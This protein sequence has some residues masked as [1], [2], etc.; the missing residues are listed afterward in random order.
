[1]SGGI[2]QYPEADVTF[3]HVFKTAGTALV[4]ALRVF[5]P[6]EVITPPLNPDALNEPTVKLY[7][8][9]PIVAGHLG[10]QARRRFASPTRAA[11][12]VLRDPVKR[13]GSVYT[14]WR[15]FLPG[16]P[17]YHASHIVAA[18]RLT[19]SEFL[20]STDPEIVVQLNNFQFAALSGSP[21]CTM[22]EQAEWLPA[23]EAL[24]AE[25]AD[26]GLTEHLAAFL[27]RMT[28]RLGVKTQYDPETL[29]RSVYSRRSTT[30]LSM[31]DEDVAY[32]KARNLIDQHMYDLVLARQ[33]G[34]QAEKPATKAA[35]KR[36]RAPSA[37]KKGSA[38]A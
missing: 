30:K 35:G 17:E 10:G 13:V 26:V 19:F 38:P 22:E 8:R 37:K 20:R 11:L 31:S 32:L 33:E 16:H 28:T 21:A 12:T 18:R 27:R 5:Y 3:D 7:S 4:E 9:F 15:E 36:T 34:A 29:L 25:F 6:I 23:G 24:L 2:T 1:M 14:Y